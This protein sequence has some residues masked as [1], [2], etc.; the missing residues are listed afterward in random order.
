MDDLVANAVEA[1][2]IST[3]DNDSP[4]ARSIDQLRKDKSIMKDLAD[5]A[6]LVALPL[7]ESDTRV[8]SVIGNHLPSLAQPLRTKWQYCTAR[9]M[10]WVLL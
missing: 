4:K 5:G 8:V 2:S 3:I 10:S 6:F 7:V 1:L 9:N